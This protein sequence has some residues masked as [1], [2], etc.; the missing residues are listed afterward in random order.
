MIHCLRHRDDITL[1]L[2]G[3]YSS[4]CD[5]SFVSRLPNVK[6][7]AADCL[8]K[9]IHVDRIATLPN[10]QSLSVGIYDL[11]DF[12]FCSMTS[13]DNITRLVGAGIK[14]PALRR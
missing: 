6:K 9:A 13:M 3:F 1:R 2:Y 4:I 7:F 8:M 5:L 12:A 14:S 11:D 10:L